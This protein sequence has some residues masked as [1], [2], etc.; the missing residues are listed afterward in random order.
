MDDRQFDSLAKALAEGKSR[1]SVLKGLLGLGGAAVAGRVCWRGRARRQGDRPPPPPRSSALATRFP[2]G[3]LAFVRRPLPTNA[4]LI[5]APVCMAVRPRPTTPSAVTTPVASAPAMGKSSAAQPIPARVDCRRLRR[6]ALALE[7]VA[8]NPIFVAGSTV[9][10]RVTAMAGHPAAIF[11]AK[12]AVRFAP[13]PATSKRF[14]VLR[15]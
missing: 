13:G 10:A 9:A 7:N 1:R 14:V 5:A 11:V 8:S 2:A 15:E 4:A 12:T 3:V 6:S